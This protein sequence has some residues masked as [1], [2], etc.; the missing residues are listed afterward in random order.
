ML[1]PEKRQSEVD[2]IRK[3]NYLWA[4]AWRTIIEEMSG[5]EGSDG[6]GLDGTIWV[7]KVQKIYYY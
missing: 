4:W 1:M 5:N 2:I 7:D 6:E 3:T